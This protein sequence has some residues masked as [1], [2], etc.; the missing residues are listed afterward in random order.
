MAACTLLAG[1]SL[2]QAPPRADPPAAL[3]PGE[4]ASVQH[5][6][7]VLAIGR[8]TKADVRAALGQAVIV[9]FP[10]GYEVWL[11]RERLP[12]KAPPPPRELVLLFPPSG[13]LAKARVR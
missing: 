3:R 8:S 2:L 4:I 11:Y 13:V 9:D 6:R 1:C 5:G 10:S 12:E 7:E